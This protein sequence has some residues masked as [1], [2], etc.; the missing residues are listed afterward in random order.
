MHSSGSAPSWQTVS[1]PY[2]GKV[3]KQ[4]KTIFSSSTL[5][6][7]GSVREGQNRRVYR[8]LVNILFKHYCVALR[9]E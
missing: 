1:E 8:K 3:N 7:E 5:R 9:I 2:I 6:R 4:E